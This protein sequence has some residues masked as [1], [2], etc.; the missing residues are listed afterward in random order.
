[1][2]SARLSS[3]KQHRENK[4]KQNNKKNPY[5]F[6]KNLAH[7]RKSK[8]LKKFP[9]RKNRSFEKEGEVNISDFS[10][11]KL[12]VRKQQIFHFRVEEL[13][14]QSQ[15]GILFAA[16]ILFKSVFIW[17]RAPKNHR[18]ILTQ[19]STLNLKSH[20]GNTSMKKIIKTEY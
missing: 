20:G 17:S 7:K 16:K 18:K 13:E 9:S 1:M 3:A 11:A 14:L 19:K 5:A 8:A 15:S 4:T 6:Y 10:T 12:D 2:N